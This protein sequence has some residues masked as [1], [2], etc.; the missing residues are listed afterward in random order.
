MNLSVGLIYITIFRSCRY[1]LQAIGPFIT[2]VVLSINLESI[3]NQLA[4][5]SSPLE[6]RLGGEARILVLTT[7]LKVK[8][9]LSVFL[10]ASV[11]KN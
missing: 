6:R 5:P 10:R 9:N 11:V 2:N 4:S 3:F 8:K 7:I 1:Y